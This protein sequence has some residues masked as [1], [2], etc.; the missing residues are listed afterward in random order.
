MNEH[1]RLVF[2]PM[3]PVSWLEI[4]ASCAALLTVYALLRRAKGAAWR[5]A[6]FALLLLILANPSLIAERRAPLKD[7]ALIVLDQSASMDL[8]DRARQAERALDSLKKKLA[9]FPD[10]DVDVA[11]AKGTSETDLF[12]VAEQRLA[13]IPPG[14]LAGIIFITDGEVHD[15]PQGAWSGPLH[16]L[17]AGQHDEIDRRIAVTAAPAYGIVGKDVTLTVRI[18]DA[19]KPQNETAAVTLRRD[20]GESET[21]DMPVGHAVKFMVPIKHAGPNLFAFSVAGVPH[22]LTMLNNETAVTVNGVRDRLRVLLISGEPHIGGRT[23]R[24]FLKSDPAVDLVHFTILRSPGSLDYTPDSELALIAFP[25]RELFETKLASFDLVIF[26]RFRQQSLIPDAYLANI[27]RYVENGGALLV[28]NATGTGIP[29]LTLSPLARVLPTTPSGQL[30]TGAFVPKLTDEGK[31]DPVT[32]TLTT[33][34]PRKDWGPWFRQSDA[35]IKS[36]DDEVLMTGLQGKPLLVLARVGQ[37]RVAQFLSDQFWLWA[38]GYK[39]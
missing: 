23:W 7:T 32:D 4:L 12:H 35:R 13:A 3:L 14:R 33:D 30:M 1:L 25:V 2:D 31:R 38:K 5:T 20:D 19:P 26:D 16:V 11:R 37:G 21:V 18:D 15:K 24:N 17:I 29:S 27:A 28:S 9:Q 6:L 34:M 8:S 36:E 22:E 39:D 10:L